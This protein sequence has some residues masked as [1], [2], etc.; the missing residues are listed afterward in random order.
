MA[1]N[2][3]SSPDEANCVEGFSARVPADVAEDRLVRAEAS[4][5]SRG[6]R[7][8]ASKAPRRRPAALTGSEEKAIE[9][10]A[11]LLENLKHENHQISPP[12]GRGLR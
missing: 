12:H 7:V 9:I 2:R 3:F 1:R 10:R 5:D 4:V 6:E 8:D 11:T